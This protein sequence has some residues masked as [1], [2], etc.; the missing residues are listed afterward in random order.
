MSYR[1]LSDENVEAATVGE[2]ERQVTMYVDDEPGSGAA[3]PEVAVAAYVTPND[4]V[5]QTNDADLLDED[6]YPGV[7]VPCFPANAVSAHGLARRVV[8]P[9]SV[10]PEPPDLPC[11]VFLTE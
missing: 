5:V 6:A 2:F 8:D 4:D 7:T 10:V 3:D 11:E 9:V 1:G